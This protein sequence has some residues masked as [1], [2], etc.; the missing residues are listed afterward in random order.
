MVLVE[1]PQTDTKRFSWERILDATTK[2]SAT[3]RRESLEGASF[4]GFTKAQEIWVRRQIETIGLPIRNINKISYKENTPRESTSLGSANLLTGEYRLY[5]LLEDPKV[6]EIA[7]LGTMVHE[8]LHWG[9][10]NREIHPLGYENVYQSEEERSHAKRHAEQIARQ[11][12]QTG[13]YLNGYHKKLF[14]AFNE[15]KID[16]TRL[17]METHAIMGELRF[18]N[19]KHLIQVQK[20]QKEK[21]EKSGR[22]NQFVQIMTQEGSDKA[23]GI[24][25]TLIS[26]L[27]D[28]GI[29]NVNQLNM[30]I[31]NVRNSFSKDKSPLR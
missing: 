3:A 27:Q 9:D 20:A 7:Q 15:G 25:R 14:E 8:G 4:E 24:D 29:H 28:K 21:L 1:S 23:V 5:K 30:H 6:P 18:T 31:E 16:E 12:K 11:T 19:P 2:E 13:V 26:L 17:K 22:G 10:P